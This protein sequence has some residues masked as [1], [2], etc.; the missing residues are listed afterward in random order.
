MVIVRKISFV[1]F[2]FFL[3]FLGLLPFLKTA[4]AASLA[5]PKDTIT[6]SRPSASAP[7]NADFT[8]GSSNVV[9][10][11][12]G[13]RFIA[14]D[15][16]KL[17]GQNLETVTVATMSASSGSPAVRTVYFAGVGTSNHTDGTVIMTPVT[18]KHTISF[19]NVGAV[20]ANGKIKIT[21]PV[22]DTTN[23]ASPSAGG[24]SFNGLS[25]TSG[26]SITGASCG[27]WTITASTGLVQCN[28]DVG[29]TGPTAISIGI[30]TT[31]P[32]LINPTKT[33]AA[34]TADTW[35]V[36]IQTTDN[37]DVVIDSSKVRIG[38]IDSVQ[39]YATV[40]ETFTFTIA[41]LTNAKAVNIG[42]TAG[43][44]IPATE[45]INTGFDSSATEVNLGVL[46]ISQVN[47]S[48]Q[49]MSIATNGISGFSLTATSSGHLID[50]ALGYWIA[51]AQ[52]TPTAN[53]T[54]IPAA[55]DAG[56]TAFGI[57]PCGQDVITTT[58]DWA[59]GAAQT[60]TTGSG[61]DCYY[62]NPS[63]TFYYTLAS[64]TT[65]PVVPDGADGLTTV[66]YAATVSSA[67]PAGTYRTALT[68]VAT[69]TF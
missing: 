32:T 31:A 52:G 4:R 50:P 55:I 45:V 54:P 60:C 46:G 59:A 42:N 58:P 17:I 8:T 36:K 64:D 21:F 39:V 27:S 26:L 68:Y 2:I 24:F 10:Y 56:T 44:T 11:D 13:T 51:D 47:I 62:A 23:V 34:G 41:G 19:T 43:C 28:L 14:S 29:L 18:A 38:T 22:G 63:P 12:N 1:L 67:V 3:T 40:E 16:A 9:F 57:H 37:G 20:P 53:E 65:G 61:T 7:I 48:A 25:A 15:S 5:S 49:L 30:G 66:E 6:T 35:S 33:A 69:P